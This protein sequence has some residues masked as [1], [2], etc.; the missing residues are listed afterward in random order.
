M[1]EKSKARLEFEKDVYAIMD[2]FDKTGYN[3]QRYK[4]LFNN[5]SNAEFDNFVK[6]LQNPQYNLHVEL[7]MYGKGKEKPLTF[8]EIERVGKKFGI[9]I[10]EYMYMP[11]ANPNDPSNPVI[12]NT[13][14]LI[15][16]V[17]VRKMQQMLSKKN[18][19]VGETDIINPITGQV[20][21]DSKA[22]SLSD[23]QT[24]G[25]VATNQLSTVYELLSLRGDDDVAERIMLNEIM[26][27][28]TCHLHKDALVPSN[29]QSIRTTHVM[30]LS[31][32]FTSDIL[33]RRQD[34]ASREDF[35]TNN[36]SFI[37]DEYG[38]TNPYR[39][40]EINSEE[41][42][43]PNLEYQPNIED[44]KNAQSSELIINRKEYDKMITSNMNKNDT[45][46]Y[47]DNKLKNKFA[48]ERVKGYINALLEYKDKY[49]GK[50]P[51]HNINTSRG[52][53][54][55][56]EFGDSRFHV[57][58]AFKYYNKLNLYTFTKSHILQYTDGRHN[59]FSRDNAGEIWIL[60]DGNN[61][62][63]RIGIYYDDKQEVVGLE[64]FG[65][66]ILFTINDIGIDRENR[67][68][69]E[70]SSMKDYGGGDDSGT[71][72][73]YFN[74]SQMYSWLRKMVVRFGFGGFKAISRMG[75]KVILLP[76][77]G[78]ESTYYSDGTLYSHY[79][80]DVHKQIVDIPETEEPEKP[81]LE[82]EFDKEKQLLEERK[83]NSKA[84]IDD[85]RTANNT[86]IENK[87]KSV[88]K[89]V[90]TD[91][92]NPNKS[93]GQTIVIASSAS[94]DANGSEDF[95]NYADLSDKKTYYN[96]KML[97]LG[98]DDLDIDIRE[99]VAQIV[100]GYEPSLII[101]DKLQPKR[102]YSAQ[103]INYE[104]ENGNDEDLYHIFELVKRA[105]YPLLV[106]TGINPFTI[107][108]SDF[109]DEEVMI[110][111]IR[112]HYEESERV[113]VLIDNKYLNNI[114][115]PEE[116]PVSKVVTEFSGYD[117]VL[118]I[119]FK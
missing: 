31:A 87:D 91:T 33:K 80:Y 20:T 30:L 92:I 67:K 105:K 51:P 34:K 106:S 58:T 21:G 29:K 55:L 72:P 57:K 37:Y 26:T 104:L 19:I 39:D 43:I 13:K 53:V 69:F 73:S 42:F 78:L 1:A 79:F 112:K 100:I 65:D 7:S 46:V 8:A 85:L 89:Q 84:K 62:I 44:V 25:L 115:S 109:K 95:S 98:N 22:A 59:K 45:R 49:H 90:L 77:W 11:F 101:Y 83:E 70:S 113:I 117:D 17:L 114:D 54:N 93:T 103:D 40:I 24:N 116:G 16:V 14:V 107:M 111:N 102:V 32:G 96:Y 10:M 12:T 15:L 118:F 76:E 68:K 63:G 4:D 2:E 88:P 38:F 61:E 97:I 66:K 52:L 108:D 94:L 110:N 23:T 6:K 9:D 18:S 75:K 64:I 82:E 48:K 119:S 56:V 86:P 71:I 81:D 41:M 5:M 36:D 47:I 28:G 60:Y 35:D 74:Y 50:F 3:T 99:K 27:T